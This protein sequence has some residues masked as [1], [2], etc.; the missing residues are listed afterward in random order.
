MLTSCTRKKFST[1][2]PTCLTF[3][4][5]LT[6]PTCLTSTRGKHRDHGKH[7]NCNAKQ[8]LVLSRLARHRHGLA[9]L[10]IK[11][12]DGLVIPIVAARVVIGVVARQVVRIERRVLMK[13][14]KRMNVRHLCWFEFLGVRVNA[15]IFFPIRSLFFFF[16]IHSPKVLL[17]AV[18]T[19]NNLCNTTP[20]TTNATAT[21]PKLQLERWLMNHAAA[22]VNAK[23]TTAMPPSRN[24]CTP[25]PGFPKTSL[26]AHILEDMFVFALAV[27]LPRWER[28]LFKPHCTIFQ[29]LK[30]LF[31]QLALQIL[32]PF[33]P[34]FFVVNHVLKQLCC[35]P[36]AFSAIPSTR[37]GLA[38][39]FSCVTQAPIL[40]FSRTPRRCRIHFA[41]FRRCLDTAVK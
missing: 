23:S 30:L 7:H 22:S 16:L 15:E 11:V 38:A 14:T 1:S 12:G 36:N 31:G 3:P 33:I 10:D 25:S 26:Y 20:R 37:V 13:R 18:S 19:Q 40:S 2:K 35:A 4:T 9:L 6:C 21:A 29:P 17:N 28:F 32:L 27:G 5:C 8:Q 41:L 24:E 39:T 34:I